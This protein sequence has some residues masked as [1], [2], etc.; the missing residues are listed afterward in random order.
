[1]SMMNP[2]QFGNIASNVGKEL[3][4]I[5]RAVTPVVRGAEMGAEGGPLGMA[6]G[7]G[8][9]LASMTPQGRTAM[10]NVGNIAGGAARGFGSGFSSGMKNFGWAGPA[11]GMI[12]G[13]AGAIRGAMNTPAAR[14]LVGGAESGAKRGFGIAGPIGGLIGGGIG[15]IGGLFHNRSNAAPASP[16]APSTPAS[17]AYTIQRGDNLS[18]IAAS[19]GTTL[20]ALR[21]ANPE[22]ASNPKYNNGNMIFAGG[23]VNIPGSSSTLNNQQMKNAAPAA[24][25][26]PRPTMAGSVGMPHPGGSFTP[27]PSAPRVGMMGGI[28]NMPYTGGGSIT[29][30]PNQKIGNKPTIQPL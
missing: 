3:V 5:T 12:G 26:I 23:K 4:P 20:G 2:A 24:P 9:G 8:L 21:A 6:A 16:A 25:S 28:Q 7:A 14:N 17:S 22:F 10:G 27:A 11:A 19:H 15:A 1:M 30:I 13:E 29:P 18:S